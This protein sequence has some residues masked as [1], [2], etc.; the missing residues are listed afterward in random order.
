MEQTLIKANEFAELLLSKK[1]VYNFVIKG[2][3]ELTDSIIQGQIDI[4][5]ISCNFLDE[6]DLRTDKIVN[7][8]F[9]KCQFKNRLF[10]FGKGYD[11]I[12]ITKCKLENYVALKKVTCNK[13]FIEQCTIDNKKLMQLQEFKANTLYFR[14][15]SCSADVLIKPDELETLTIEGNENYSLISYSGQDIK[16]PLKALTLFTFSNYKTDYLIRSFQAEKLH[17]VGELKDAILTINNCKVNRGILHGFINQGTFIINGLQQLSEE[18]MLIIKTS[19]LGKAQ[20]N[21]I[22]FS[23][24]KQVFLETSNLLE[25]LPVNVKWC[26]SK[27][28]KNKNLDSQKENY[29]QLKIIATKN[30][31]IENKLFFYNLEMQTLLKIHKSFR[32]KFNDKFILHT[33]L[34]S[35]RFGLS[36]VQAFCWLF[37]TSILFYIAIKWTLGYRYFDSKLI[38]DDCGRF[39]SF[40]NP[41]H[42]FDKTFGVDMETNSNGG[43]LI[44]GISKITGAYFIYQFISSFRK[45]S[46]K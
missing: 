20:I 11:H 16:K 36:W 37:F 27:N 34:L 26:T 29:R 21:N 43:L 17:I 23:V 14:R 22:D 4:E 15:N 1:K 44:D 35:N 41:I 25:V 6:C 5:I 9:T 3:F 30:E 12:S 28:I 18:S 19:Y 40:I 32:L 10:I 42:Q 24:F 38:L 46:N 2:K 39:L 31:D 8:H 33:N 7:V 13:L 45:Y